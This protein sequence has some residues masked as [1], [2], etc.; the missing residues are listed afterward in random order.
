LFGRSRAQLEAAIGAERAAIADADAARVLLAVNVART[1][2]QLARLVE[3]RDVLQRALA[4]R[5][6]TYSLTNERV[7]AGLDT[8]VELRQ[9]EGLRPETRQQLEAVEEQIA[10]SRHALA[11]LLAEPPQRFDT[12][13]PTLTTLRPVAIPDVVPADLVG[14]RADVVAARWRVEGPSATL[15]RTQFYPNINLIA[16]SAC[17]ASASIV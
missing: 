2:L 3:Q 17:R 1:Y 9:S 13:A 5:E 14:R 11:A 16:F 7:S 8:A 10:L 6:E 12:L 15:L 4:Q